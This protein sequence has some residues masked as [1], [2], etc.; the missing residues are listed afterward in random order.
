VLK[1][2]KLL[3]T[4]KFTIFKVQQENINIRKLD[5]HH[6]NEKSV[7]LR[8]G[9]LRIFSKDGVFAQSLF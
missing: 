6:Q 5:Q 1:L 2:G 3:L 7:E 8:T 9:S 4:H